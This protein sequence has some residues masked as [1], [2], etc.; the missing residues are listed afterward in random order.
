MD[1]STKYLG[2]SL[3]N[4]I[5]V[6]SCGLTK[7]V[8]QIKQCEQAG[9]GAVVMK[10]LLEEQI[11]EL[12][13]DIEDDMGM[14]SEVMGYLQADIG[15]RY[16]SDSYTD[17]IEQAKKEVSIPVIASVNCYTSK[18]WANYAKQLE[19]AGAQVEIK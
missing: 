6:A 14:H 8:E 15:M 17:T 16:G 18:W 12:E 19:E 13:A 11:R 9:A 10:S 4:P 3:K 7:T 5:I 1:L 2:L